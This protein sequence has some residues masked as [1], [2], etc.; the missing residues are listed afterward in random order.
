MEKMFLKGTRKRK[1]LRGPNG[2]R[3]FVSESFR[4]D[5]KS[6]DF[7]GLILSTTY[8]VNSMNMYL[9][10]VCVYIYLVTYTYG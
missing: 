4:F 1:R 3:K 2:F 6:M 10:H 7:L 9:E 8:F 5:C